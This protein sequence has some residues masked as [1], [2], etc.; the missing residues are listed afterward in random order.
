MMKLTQ[1]LQLIVILVIAGMV[2]ACRPTNSPTPTL[3]PTEVVVIPPATSAPTAEPSA[4]PLQEQSFKAATYKDNVLGIQFDYP[5][6]WTLD[7]PVAAGGRANLV[8]F[9]SW[10]H[11]P[12][13]LSAETPPGGTR[14]DAT[15]WQWDPKKDLEAFVASRQTAW[16]ASGIRVL[17]EER[18]Y[19]AAGWP[20]VAFVIQTP[21]EQA[22]FFFTTVGDR[23][24]SLS[25]S[26]NLSLL[27]EIGKTFR[28]ISP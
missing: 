21:G 11:A 27:A 25:G 15:V 17:S 23:Y 19:I 9:T 10:A 3:E 14:M 5:V 12:G 26:G 2:A 1:F 28:P 20:G 8:Q 6:T 22:Y 7:S 24:F 4:T 13:D 16:E 18:L